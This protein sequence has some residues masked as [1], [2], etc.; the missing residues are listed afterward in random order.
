MPMAEL[1]GMESRLSVPMKTIDWRTAWNGKR[2]V[3]LVWV[4][5]SCL[6]PEAGTVEPAR[7][8]IRKHGTLDLDMVETTPLVFRDRLYRFEYVRKEHHAN[9]TGDSYFRFFDVESG[10][11]TAAFAR[12]HHLGCAFAEGETIWIFGVDRWDGED[13]AVFRSRDLER[14]EQ[15]PA[16]KLPGWG[17]FNTSVCKAG[18]R[19]VMAIEVGR[20]PEVVGVPFTMRFAESRNLLDWTLLPEAC[21]FTKERYSACPALRYFDGTFYMLYLEARTGPSYETHLVRSTDL[22][23]WEASPLNPVL[24]ASPEDKQ[25]ANP[26]LTAAQRAKVAGAVDRNNSDMDLCEFRGR[27]IITYSWGNQQGTE[28]L[29]EASYDGSLA[30]FFKGFFP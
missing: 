28:F 8:E 29:A 26:N 30:A 16:L 4:L 13:I 7:P 25:I 23:R 19:Y 15:R 11:A 12:G 10:R 27:T 1:G 22:V 17:L 2:S 20:P 24:R 3:A 5:C 18:N 9:R 14:W 6:A 21:V